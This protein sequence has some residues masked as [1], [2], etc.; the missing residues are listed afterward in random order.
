MRTSVRTSELKCNKD[1]THLL[2][3]ILFHVRLTTRL[4]VAE[5][6][7]IYNA[8]YNRLAILTEI[9]EQEA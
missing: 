8:N 6:W 4:A 2:H 3:F 1:K 5:I 7:K 9:V